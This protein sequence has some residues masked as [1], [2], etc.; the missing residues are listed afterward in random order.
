[1][2][3]ERFNKWKVPLRKRKIQAFT[4]LE[5]IIVVTIIGIM[6]SIAIPNYI[7]ARERSINQEAFTVLRLIAAAENNYRLISQGRYY[8]NDPRIRKSLDE[9][10]E[11]LGIGLSSTSD[12]WDFGISGDREG[13]SFTASM[14]RKGPY[15]RTYYIDET[16]ETTCYGSCNL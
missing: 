11:Y 10:N 14:T 2:E 6:A 1:M 3:Q 12:R 5:L 8:P 4:L 13:K 7:K 15:P 9:V 16:N